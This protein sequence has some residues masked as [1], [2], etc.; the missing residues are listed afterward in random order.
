MRG[1]SNRET[2]RRVVDAV[3]PRSVNLHLTIDHGQVLTFR[4]RT[5]LLSLLCSIPSRSRPSLQAARRTCLRISRVLR[6]RNGVG[7]HRLY[8][9]YYPCRSACTTRRHQ[10]ST[11]T[12]PPPHHLPYFLGEAMASF[13]RL[14]CACITG[15]YTDSE[16]PRDFEKGCKRYHKIYNIISP[17]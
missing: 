16:T 5:H 9:P 10:S 6:G 1:N 3:G 7:H 8:T 13:E 15:R 12:E 11:G 4:S 17:C 14:T 2:E